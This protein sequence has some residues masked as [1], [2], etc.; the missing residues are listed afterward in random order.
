MIGCGLGVARERG[1]MSVDQPGREARS[2]RDRVLVVEDDPDVADAVRRGLLFAGFAVDLA[3]DGRSA[4]TAIAV[5]RPDVLVLDLMLPDFD[6]LELCRQVRAA[7]AGAN[8]APLPILMLTARDAVP[9]RVVGLHAG[10]DDYLVKPFAFEELVARL[11]ALLRRVRRTGGEEPRQLLRYADVEL[12]LAGRLVTRGARL[13]PLTTREFDLLA[14]FFQHP[15]RVLSRTVLMDRFW[16]DY[17]GESN[18]LEVLIASL[19]RALE[20]AGEPRLIHTV[21]GVGYVLRAGE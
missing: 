11:Q 13:V 20:A 1:A 2:G 14:L 12:D 8:R 3:P 10:A 15:Q 18:V 16:S 19:R 7:E 4:L 5:A 9:D 6:G 21:R 17:Y